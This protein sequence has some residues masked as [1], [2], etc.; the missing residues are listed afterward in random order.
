MLLK[1]LVFCLFSCY[2]HSDASASSLPSFTIIGSKLKDSSKQIKITYSDVLEAIVA[3]FQSNGY[4]KDYLSLLMLKEPEKF[5]QIFLALRD[6]MIQAEISALI[7]EKKNYENTK[8]GKEAIEKAKLK[9]YRSAISNLWR[10]EMKKAG[11]GI[12]QA[13]LEVKYA[14][15]LKKYPKIQ[16]LSGK[17]IIVASKDTAD[18]IVRS[19]DNRKNNVS[20]VDAFVELGS[21][22]SLTN[23]VQT[24]GD[25]KFTKAAGEQDFGQEVVDVLFKAKEYSVKT[26]QFGEKTKYKS[27]YGIFLIVKI[28]NVEPPKLDVIS[29]QIK[30]LIVQDMINAEIDAAKNEI[31]VSHYDKNGVLTDN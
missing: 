10:D 7:A 8:D 19:L 23:F 30:S 28:S 5:K 22:H 13:Q 9:A 2:I 21:Q 25:V 15:V 11:S 6:S 18:K 4:S 14:E 3:F 26:V 12:T 20:I 24:K 16:E 1:S 27:K 17:M 31:G 29:E